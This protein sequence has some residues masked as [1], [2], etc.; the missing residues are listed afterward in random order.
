[1]DIALRTESLVVRHKGTIVACWEEAGRWGMGPRFVL[2]VERRGA[3]GATAVEF[4][5]AP[6]H[7][8]VGDARYATGRDI[9]VA[10]LLIG[11]AAIRTIP[12]PP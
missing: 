2:G 9:F 10:F 8:C 11:G 6:W 3:D 4:T 5:A 12:T 1:M 7:P